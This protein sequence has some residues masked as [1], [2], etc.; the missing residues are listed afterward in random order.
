[1][2]MVESGDGARLRQV[3]FD[4]VDVRQ[5]FRIGNLDRHLPLQAV[6]G[7]QIEAAEATAAQQ[8]PDPVAPDLARHGPRSRF[9]R[10]LG[11][12]PAGRC[13]VTA[14]GSVALME[15]C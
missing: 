5:Q 8:S 9:S 2:R 6:V 14:K 12:V 3:R 13:L 11:R 7:G 10:C 4:V 15:P 1:M